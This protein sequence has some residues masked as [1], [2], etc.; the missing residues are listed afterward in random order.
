PPTPDAEATAEVLATP[1]NPIN[2]PAAQVPQALLPPAADA[3]PVEE[4]LREVFIEEAGEVQAE[5]ERWLPTW[6]AEPEQRT[7]LSELRRN[8]HTLKGS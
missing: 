7:A 8:F 2:P 1:V 3:E 4:E 6:Q 5:L